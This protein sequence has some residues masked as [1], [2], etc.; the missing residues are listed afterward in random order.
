[1]CVGCVSSKLSSFCVVID[2]LCLLCWMIYSVCMS[3]GSGSG[4]IINFGRWNWNSVSVGMMVMFRLVVISVVV[5]VRCLIFMLLCSLVG[6]SV[7]L[8]YWWMLVLCVRW[9]NGVLMR[10][11]MVSVGLCVSG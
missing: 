6:C 8:R 5:V 4:C 9:M 7:V 3:L 1:M 10:L 2:R 11:F